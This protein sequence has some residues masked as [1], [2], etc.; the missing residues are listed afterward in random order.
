MRS[1]VALAVLL[2]ASAISFPAEPENP[3]HALLLFPG[4]DQPRWVSLEDKWALESKAVR[5]V[6]VTSTW[7][8]R[9]E[10]RAKVAKTNLATA[11][12]LETF[13]AITQQDTVRPLIANLSTTSLEGYLTALTAF[14]NRHYNTTTGRD[15]A[16]SIYDTAVSIASAAGRA[17]DVSV[18]QFEH[19]GLTQPIEIDKIPQPS[20]IA[21]IEGSDPSAPLVVLG[22]HLDSLGGAGGERA[23]G[24]DDNASGSAA[25]LET[26]RALLQ[27]GYAPRVPLEFHWYA[28][29]EAGFLGS[30]Q[31][32][33]A[34]ARAGTPV[35]AM[36]Q[37]DMT[38]YTPPGETP[39]VTFITDYTDAPLT[40]YL[41]SLVDEYLSIGAATS[42]C[43][44]PCSDHWPWTSNGYPSAFPFET[45]VEKENPYIHT[46]DDTVDVPGFS[47]DHML[48]FTKLAVAAAVELTA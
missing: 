13:P 14:T 41:T 37:F 47:Y 33:A 39:A 11:R 44:Y 18:S 35:H 28:G 32:A 34:Y 29:E 31:V 43:Q 23:P 30:G 15:A 16:V 12:L 24:A 5:F 21:R 46:P 36:V 27:H 17:D 10:R 40:T 3:G 7:A 26:Y 42:R 1:C 2:A 6:D 22:A 25:L 9:N 19:R 8:D 4:N 45:A 48:E 20:I 38:A